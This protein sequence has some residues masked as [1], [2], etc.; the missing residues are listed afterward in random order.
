M[1]ADKPTSTFP[2]VPGSTPRLAIY[3]PSYSN[4]SRK[5]FT[6]LLE[7]ARVADRLGVDRVSLPEHVV[8]GEQL[9]DF[10]RPEV[11][12]RRGGKQPTGPD[13]SFL[14]PLVLLGLLAGVTGRIRLG[15]AVLLAALRQPIVLAKQAATVDVLSSGRLDLGVGIGWQRDEYQAAGVDWTIR[16]RL[17]DHCLEICRLLWTVERASH[18]SELLDFENIHQMPKP[19]QESGVPIWV[20]GAVIQPVLERIVKYGSGWL[21]WDH[22]ADEMAP[23]IASIR[24]A[25]VAAGRDPE[26]FAISF[27]LTPPTSN[28]PAGFGA[29]LE[30]VPELVERGV[31]DF[32]MPVPSDTREA[33]DFLS[34]LVPAFR[35]VVS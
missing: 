23:S 10:A 34:V 12:G 16:G 20:G 25:L 13:G 5:D 32:H 2:T 6:Y 33:E 22:S 7:V 19:N 4:E 8:F 21:P 27:N 18:H 24:R 26:T 28:D 1:M 11:G 17:L 30:R 14:E 3:I 15:T 31:T 9:E 29:V 35:S